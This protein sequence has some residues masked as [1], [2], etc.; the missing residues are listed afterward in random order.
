MTKHIL[1]G[2][3]LCWLLN[4]GAKA[5]TL[6]IDP[7]LTPT[8]I[9]TGVAENN[10]MS[11][12]KDNQNKIEALQTATAA[13]VTFINDWQKKTYNGLLY[14]SSTLKNV[15]Q[16]VECGLVLEKIYDYESKMLSEAGKNPIALAFASKLQ[17]D[18]VTRAINSFTSIQT[19]ILKEKDGNLLMDAG[20]RMKLLN[21]VL[22]D[23][24]VIESLAASSYFKVKWAVSQGI[25]NSINPFGGITNKDAA[26]TKDILSTWKF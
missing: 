20:E 15:Y 26:I 7:V 22:M 18:M 2:V 17:V 11:D 10:A 24:R 23:L 3:S 5:Q 1:L 25:I 6:T 21:N 14:V 16:V 4:L 19:L 9:L 12:I 8:I 13:T